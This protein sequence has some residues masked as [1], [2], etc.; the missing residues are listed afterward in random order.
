MSRFAECFTVVFLGFSQIFLNLILFNRS[1][2]GGDLLFFIALILWILVIPLLV[3]Y[4][5][6]TILQRKLGAKSFRIWRSIVY[7]LT[8]LSICRQIQ[9]IYPTGYSKILGWMPVILPYIFV[10]ALTLF[11][12]MKFN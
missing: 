12:S 11:L 2:F 4:V 10:A 3:L 5:V 7:T 9:I 8:I 1:S 6:D